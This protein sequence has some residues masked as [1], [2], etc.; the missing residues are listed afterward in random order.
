MERM[1]IRC[2]MCSCFQSG[3][4]KNGKLM[5][6]GEGREH[7]QAVKVGDFWV[8]YSHPDKKTLG[9]TEGCLVVPQQRWNVLKLEKARDV[10]MNGSF[11]VGDTRYNPFGRRVRGYGSPLILRVATQADIEQEQR[12]KDESDAKRKAQ[13]EETERREQAEK[14]AL[15]SSR[16][17]LPEYLRNNVVAVSGF[18]EGKWEFTVVVP[19]ELVA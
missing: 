3:Q 10:K 5:L 12:E 8:C 9:V 14:E 19:R 18:Y 16:S 2:A 1:R 13:K 7:I 11:L 15:A 6:G 17:K 4:L